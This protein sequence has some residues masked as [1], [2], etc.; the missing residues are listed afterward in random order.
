MKK[1][2]FFLLLM[3]FVAC[4]DYAEMLES[5]YGQSQANDYYDNWYDEGG[6][7]GSY[8]GSQDSYDFPPEQSNQQLCGDC[9]ELGFKMTRT[10]VLIST[11]KYPGLNLATATAVDAASASSADLI[12]LCRGPEINIVSE[13]YYLSDQ[14]VDWNFSLADGSVSDVVHKGYNGGN[15]I[16]KV[17]ESR[18]QLYL[19]RN[20]AVFNE[21][22]GEGFYAFEIASYTEGYN[23]NYD[24][25]VWVYRAQ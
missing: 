14:V 4:T 1:V 24:L 6:S 12:F 5:D 15:I 11:D 19:A 21:I 17:P 10:E 9:Q 20:P 2:L 18:G 13:S 7:Q 3:V 25:V 16:S 23:G 8:G 22:T